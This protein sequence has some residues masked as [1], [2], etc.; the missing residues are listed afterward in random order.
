MRHPHL[1]SAVHALLTAFGQDRGRVPGDAHDDVLQFLA[2]LIQLMFGD[3]KRAQPLPVTVFD[4]LS[5]ALASH[6]PLVHALISAEDRALIARHHDPDT[7]PRLRRSR[8]T[9]GS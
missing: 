2:Q 4:A 8:V 3:S 5:H 1:V 9:P 6:R 7:G